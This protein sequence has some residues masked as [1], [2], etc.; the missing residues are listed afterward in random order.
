MII[1]NSIYLPH[2]VGVG[3]DVWRDAGLSMALVDNLQSLF[4]ARCT[5]TGTN[6]GIE[7][8]NVWS[9]SFLPHLCH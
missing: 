5:R 4:P 8:D 7:R 9:D 1:R 3:I 6:D 2:R